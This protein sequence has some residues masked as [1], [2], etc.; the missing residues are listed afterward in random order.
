MLM[1]FK[2][3]LHTHLFPVVSVCFIEEFYVLLSW[4][5]FFTCLLFTCDW[6]CILK[7]CVQHKG[8]AKRKKQIAT[9][10]YDQEKLGDSFLLIGESYQKLRIFNKALKWC[11][12]SWKIYNA[13]GNLEVSSMCKLN[14]YSLMNERHI[15]F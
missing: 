5:N 7:F 8:F 9:K 10:L 14:K 4:Y 12:K 3:M 1:L 11:T 6:H 13:I 2:Y 15:Q